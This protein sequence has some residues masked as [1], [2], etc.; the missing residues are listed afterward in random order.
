MRSGIQD[1]L[2]VA[3]DNLDMA[4]MVVAISNGN[5]GPGYCTVGSPGTAARGSDGRRERGRHDFVGAPVTVG[6]SELWRCQA[7]ISASGDR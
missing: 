6:G 3:V 7:A 4:N 5:E 1:L 2:T